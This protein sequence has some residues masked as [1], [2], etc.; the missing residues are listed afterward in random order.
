M[1][2]RDRLVVGRLTLDQVTL[3]RIQVPE[4]YLEEGSDIDVIIIIVAPHA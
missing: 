2:F 4:H 3:V 1:S